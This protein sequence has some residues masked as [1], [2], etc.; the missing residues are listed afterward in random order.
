MMVV[1]SCFIVSEVQRFKER[2][3]SWYKQ[4]VIYRDLED[5]KNGSQN[6]INID[7]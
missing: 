7:I 3:I 5:L 2:M 4:C 6:S 1:L